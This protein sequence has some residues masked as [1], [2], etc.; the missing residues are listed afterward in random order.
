MSIQVRSGAGRDAPESGDFYAGI[1]I[2][3]H[4]TRMLVVAKNGEELTPLLTE[5]RVTRLAG[6]FT[7]NGSITAEAM[8][9]NISAL[10]EY[11]SLLKRF[12]PV[13]IACGATGVVRRA[14]NS[15]AVIDGM[16]LETGIECG[17]LSEET[18]AV[19]SAR[20]V[21]SVLPETDEDLLTFDIGGGST[22][23]LFAAHGEGLPVPSASRP[24]GAATLT[25]AFLREDPPGMEA[26]RRA[27]AFAGTEIASAR[28]IIYE[29]LNNSG[30]IPRHEKLRLAG[31]AGTVTTLAAMNIGMKKYVPYRVNGLVLTA[32]WL[33]GLTADLA[34][35][36][37]A[38][39]RLIDGLEPGR[40]DIILGG[41]VIVSEVLSRFGVDRFTV[42][43]A[44]LLEGLVID[45]VE[46]KSGAGKGCA[47]RLRT[48]LTW[49]PQKR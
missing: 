20:G 27:V 30:I 23:F 29:S 26:V 18:E 8:L 10:K 45:A 36:P 42:T 49:R 41:A 9:R 28:A 43:D 5:R 33:S 17:V 15:R 31:T 22:E 16:A 12:Q 35:M 24:V 11:A 2:G 6:G 44:G 47:A 21:L 1:D 39:R 34:L 19:L 13:R 40:E 25:N 46:K 4:T 7:E 14:A 3:S 48:G 37:L 32:D 38:R